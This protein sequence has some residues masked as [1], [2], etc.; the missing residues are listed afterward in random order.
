MVGVILGGLLGGVR[1]TELDVSLVLRYG[2]FLGSLI[3]VIAGLRAGGT[4]C[5]QHMILRWRLWKNGSLPW[6]SARFL[7]YAA[8][9]ILLRKVGGG[10]IFAHRL[11][12]EYLASLE[13]S[14]LD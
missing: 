12:L 10:Y 3:G 8:E 6:H 1:T 11:L 13:T 5:I 9:H 4:A 7:D 2:L 14:L